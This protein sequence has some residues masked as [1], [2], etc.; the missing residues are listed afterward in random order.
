MM[1]QFT[2]KSADGNTI[3]VQAQTC[4]QCNGLGCL[5]KPVTY[6]MSRMVGREAFETCRAEAGDQCPFCQ[7]LGWRQIASPILPE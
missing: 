5:T 3:E 7:G 4:S 6:K 2:Q 1:A